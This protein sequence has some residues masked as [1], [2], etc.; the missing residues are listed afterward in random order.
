MDKNVQV[1]D[2]STE[3]ILATLKGHTKKVTAALFVSAAEGDDLPY[4]LASSSLDKTIRLW[5]TDTSAKAKAS[6]A[7][8][9]AISSHSGEVNALAVHPCGNLLASAGSDGWAFHDI[10]DP[11]KPVTFTQSALPD[12]VG[13]TAIAFHGDGHLLAVGAENGKIYVYDTKTSSFVATFEDAS[14]TG[15]ITS[16][17]F[18]EN[19]YILATA[20][21]KSAQVWDMRKQKVNAT[22]S[23]GEGEDAKIISVAWDHSAQ[24]LACAGSSVQIWQNKS[25]KEPLVTLEENASDLS[26]VAW[27]KQGKELV[28]AGLDRTVRV[29]VPKAE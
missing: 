21:G 3:K 17:S 15:P 8:K 24:F 11:A 10:T 16:I 18:S 20:S 19:G 14:S 26:G 27:A 7:A 12:E 25:W 4:L 6:Y 9:A 13:G 1:Y 23:A 28:V 22:L 29:F 2:R 5:S